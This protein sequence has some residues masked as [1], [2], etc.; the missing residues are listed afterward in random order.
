M[1]MNA[2]HADGG[3]R[4]RRQLAAEQLVQLGAEPPRSRSPRR[5]MGPIA[6]TQSK[7]RIAQLRRSS[8]GR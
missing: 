4:E 1:P 2:G 6:G 7:A 8:P 3:D 5:V